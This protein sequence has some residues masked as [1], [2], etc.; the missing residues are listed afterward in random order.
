M[1]T[2]ERDKKYF[3]RGNEA[4]DLKVTKAKGSLIYDEQGNKYIDFL[5]GAGVGSLGWGNEEIENEIRKNDRP[6]YVYPNFYYEPWTQLAKLLADLTPT[7]LTTSFRTTGGSEAVE[8]AM[9]MAMMYT[10]RKKFISVEGS[11]HGNTIASISLGASSKHSS[12][13]NLLPGCE[14]IDL[15][16][17]DKALKTLEEKLKDH[18]LAGFIM[19][20]VICNLG[21]VIPSSEFME[22]LDNLCKQYGTLLIMDEAIT[23]FGRTGKIFAT[24]HFNIK[25]DM[26]CMAKAMSAGHA[27]IGA[28][29]ITDEIANKVEED[30]GLYSSYGW[31]PISVDAS[32]VAINYLIEHKQQLFNNIKETGKFFEQQLK[33]IN[34]NAETEIRIKGLAIGVDVKDQEYATQIRKRS[35]Q[36]GLL[37]DTEGSSL[38]F[39]PALNIDIKTAKEGL[40]ILE[41]SVEELNR[42]N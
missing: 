7:H 2:K 33:D 14:K 32:L 20:P 12:F 27:G 25:P 39:F 41:K 23:G 28:V 40:E 8:A 42:E 35:L 19:E 30:V 38:V 9:Q 29:I 1:N 34:F 22:K 21:V 5:G 31:H 11:Y 15:P 37:M 24:E 36:H 6:A 26:I 17:D 3:G 4:L 13:P 10:G 16:L 18:S